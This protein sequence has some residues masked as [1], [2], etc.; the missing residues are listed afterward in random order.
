MSL[1]MFS[2]FV[3]LCS[4]VSCRP[5]GDLLGTRREKMNAGAGLADIDPMAIDQ[6]VSCDVHELMS[7]SDFCSQLLSF[8]IPPLLSSSGG[9]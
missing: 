5:L 3:C 9:L 4:S 2:I 6:S 7:Q 8:I 1:L